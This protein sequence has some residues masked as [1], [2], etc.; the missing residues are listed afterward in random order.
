VGRAVEP[1]SL[2]PIPE[3]FS[4]AQ[5][6]PQLSVLKDADVFITHGGMNSISEAVMYGVP[7]IVV[8]NTVEQALNAARVEQLLGGIYLES[9]KLTVEQLQITADKMTA[10]PAFGTGL[11][12]IRQSFLDGGGV[13]R[14]AEAIEKFKQRYDLN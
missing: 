5:F 14:A 7:M 13:Q 1:S 11:E 2:E 6:V 3:N 8:P 10:D 4:V 12:R 9:H